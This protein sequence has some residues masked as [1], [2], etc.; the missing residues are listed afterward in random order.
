MQEEIFDPKPRLGI[1]ACLLGEKVR[2]D[3]GDKKD[4]FLTETFGRHVEWVPVCPE[5]EIGMGIPREAV[6]LVGD[7][8]K[9]RMIAERSGKEWTPK[10]DS[11][12][13]KRV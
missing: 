12:A 2:Y 1:S 9:P 11:F 8:A 5:V 4:D 13:A 3:G 10:F 7:P 6:R